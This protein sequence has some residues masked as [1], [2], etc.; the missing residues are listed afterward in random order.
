MAPRWRIRAGERI[1]AIGDIHG[2]EDLF[3]QLISL[4]RKDNA[5]R[6]PSKTR[7]IVLGDVIDRGPHPASLVERLIRYGR[8]RRFTVLMGNHER[9]MLA[10]L[11]GDATA[12]RVWLRH[13]GDTTLRSWGMQEHLITEESVDVMIRQARR[14]IPYQVLKWLEGLRLYWRSGNVLFVH[15]G[16]RCGVPLSEQVPADLLWINDDFIESTVMHPFLVVHGHTVVED[17]PDVRANRIGIDTGAYRTGRLT[18]LG[19]ENDRT[20]SLAAVGSA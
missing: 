11:L 5:L 4:I 3:V 12:A 19:L 10:A 16:V 20:W 15:A 18:A 14:L 13:G 1:Y 8:N 6:P 2:R 7:I 17:G 9:I